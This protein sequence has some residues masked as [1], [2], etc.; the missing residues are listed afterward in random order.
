MNVILD[1]LDPS[2]STGGGPTE[3]SKDEDGREEPDRLPEVQYRPF[4][5]GSNEL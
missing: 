2:N 4:S 5:D 1:Q 3:E